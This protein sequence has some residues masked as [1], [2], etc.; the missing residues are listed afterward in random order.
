[1]LIE[2]PD[3]PAS[4]CGSILAGLD[5]LR[6]ALNLQAEKREP[7]TMDLG[8]SYIALLNVHEHDVAF[9]NMPIPAGSALIT[10]E[11]NLP[12]IMINAEGG[13]LFRVIGSKHLSNSDAKLKLADEINAAIWNRVRELE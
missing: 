10:S 12:W 8:D 5:R 9:H 4:K 1:M 6:V 3:I 7:C 13:I 11:A 2:N